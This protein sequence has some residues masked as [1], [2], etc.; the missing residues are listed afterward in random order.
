MK[1]NTTA[2]KK[3]QISTIAC[4]LFTLLFY[5]PVAFAQQ[6]K[7]DKPEV[8]AKKIKIFG[9]AQL[10]LRHTELNPG[11]VIGDEVVSD[12]YDLTVR[13]YRLGAIGTISENISYYF[14]IGNNNLSIYNVDQ[15]PQLLDA[16]VNFKLDNSL[17]ITAGKGAWTGLSRY[18]SPSSSSGL[19]QDI[20][21]AAVPLLNYH[22]NLLRK[23][24]VT[25]HGL[26]NKVDYRLAFAKPIRSSNPTNLGENARLIYSPNSLNVSGYFKYQF[27]DK[28]TQ[29]SAYMPGTYLGTKKILNIGAGFMHHSEV[30]ATLKATDTIRHDAKSFAV[31]VFF[32]QKLTE[33]HAWTFYGAWINH[34]IGPN[35]IRNLGADNPAEG[36]SGNN[37][38]FNGKGNSFPVSGTGNSFVM[39]L[40]YQKVF[41]NK[42]GE[43]FGVQP[44][45]A[46]QHSEYE[47]LETPMTVYDGGINYLM[48]G[49]NSMLSLNFQSRPVYSLGSATAK[50][51]IDKRLS[52]IVLMYQIKLSN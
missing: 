36:L 48:D 42:K 30:S 29:Q 50:P 21:F 25:L 47:A 44:Y 9:S 7:I 15:S 8:K 22:D 3:M 41:K 33:G 52:M 2:I 19:T 14:Q 31:D 1:N 4:M 51:S 23:P 5:V 38:S 24:N 18:A 40:G 34:D 46:I 35:Y 16:H 10:W 45:I 26:I 27:F 11:S 37:V 39:Q 43:T 49:H 17:I 28:E 20:N 13:R 6:N 12:A 32:D